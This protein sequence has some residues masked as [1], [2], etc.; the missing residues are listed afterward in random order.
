MK[1]L[2]IQ[3][4]YEKRWILTVVE[5]YSRYSNNFPKPRTFLKYKKKR[6][7]TY[8][9]QT[10]TAVTSCILYIIISYTILLYF[11]RPTRN[12]CVG[13]LNAIKR[14][15]LLLLLRLVSYI[16]IYTFHLRCPSLS[17]YRLSIGITIGVAVIRLLCVFVPLPSSPTNRRIGNK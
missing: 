8:R 7:L 16:Y 15:L 6:Y 13:V 11:P 9:R 4:K 2:R 3:T 1:T 12:N 10:Y 5:L 17:S 14:D